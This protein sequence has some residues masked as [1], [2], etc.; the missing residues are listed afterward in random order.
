MIRKQATV[1]VL[2]ASVIGL[3]VAACGSDPTAT[4]APTPTPTTPV[5]EPTP[6]VDPFVAQW[7]ELVA[8]AQAEG[9][10]QTFICCGL[11]RAL[12]DVI[13]AFE[14]KFDVKVTNSTG[15]S[16]QQVVKVQAERAAGQFTLDVWV[17]G[18]ATVTDIL[19][20]EG[21]VDPIKPLIIHPEV[22]DASK[23]YTGKLP[24]LGPDDG[25]YIFGLSA[26][27]TLANLGY[28]TDLLPDPTVIQSY[29]D[30]LKPEF[31]GKIVMQDPRFPGMANGLPFYLNHPDL[32]ESFM[33]SLITETNMNFLEARPLAEAVA[34]GKYTLCIFCGRDLGTIKRDGAPV[35]DNFP[36]SLAEGA[37]IGVGGES[38]YFVN[39]APHPN[40]AKLFINWLLTPEGMLLAQQ[41]S[42]AD[43][44]RVDLPNDGV[45]EGDIRLDG[46]EYYWGESIPGF[47]DQISPAQAL[48]RKI[49]DEAG[50]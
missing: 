11:G 30:L 46:V 47:T 42:G 50:L 15:G 24:F 8:A 1:L 5:G 26:N 39:G 29:K 3:L 37:T 33:R 9:E 35:Q 19:I 4:P 22:L 12:T 25:A 32:G 2:L 14:A 10:V 49:M 13:A 27:A 36:H 7:A 44:L 23:W 16:S 48:M 45:D 34:L 31:D 28:N 20:P 38:L 17:G 40:A 43:S 41:A 18:L 21:M 6:T